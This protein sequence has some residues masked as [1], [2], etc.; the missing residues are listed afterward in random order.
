MTLIRITPDRVPDAA[1]AMSRAML[2]EPGG[3]WLFPDED[4][5]IDLHQQ[6]YLASMT[7]AIIPREHRL[8]HG[9]TDTLLRLSIGIEDPDDLI[10][11][12]R[13]ALD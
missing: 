6:I 2:D 13:S 7:H 10:E 1:A 8:E 12:L 9:I 11:D 4:E 3:R 5:F